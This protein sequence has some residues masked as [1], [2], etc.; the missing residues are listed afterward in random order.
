MPTKLWR[1]KSALFSEQG[2]VLVIGLGAFAR[3]PYT[4]STLAAFANV[5]SQLWLRGVA[6]LHCRS[7]VS[8][9]PT[10]MLRL[11]KET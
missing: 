5:S 9:N 3:P 7:V 10:A 1:K 8:A 6:W 2:L 4:T 11:Q